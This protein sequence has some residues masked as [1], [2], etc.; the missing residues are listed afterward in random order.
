VREEYGVLV[1]P[2]LE[3]FAPAAARVVDGTVIISVTGPGARGFVLTQTRDGA[4]A[5]P[6]D[7]DVQGLEVRGVAGRYTASLGELEWVE[8]GYAV[9]LRSDTL[10]VDEL[11]AIAGR[12]EP[13]GRDPT[14]AAR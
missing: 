11:V 12:L 7:P 14:E 2:E 8:G 13:A 4:L 10:T 5:P 9:S 3:G 6:L 1:P